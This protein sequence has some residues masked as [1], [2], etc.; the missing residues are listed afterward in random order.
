MQ[1]G[2]NKCIK[3]TNLKNVSLR[4]TPTDERN[5]FFLHTQKLLKKNI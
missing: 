4:R 3:K 1:I 5:T 2:K